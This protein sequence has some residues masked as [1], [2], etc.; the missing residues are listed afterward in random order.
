M[1]ALQGVQALASVLGVR[2]GGVSWFATL[3]LLVLPS[4]PFYKFH[5]TPT[6]HN[7]FSHKK[8]C[9]FLSLAKVVQPATHA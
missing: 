1:T 3:G 7:N 5:P 9:D 2:R 4:Y 8:I 6:P